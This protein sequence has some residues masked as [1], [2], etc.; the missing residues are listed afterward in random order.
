M[1]T[2]LSSIAGCLH[3]S[4]KFECRRTDD[5]RGSGEH[6]FGHAVQSMKKD[7]S[8]YHSIMVLRSHAEAVK[9]SD[10]L[11][12]CLFSLP[13]L[14]VANS[15]HTHGVRLSFV[16]VA[17]LCTLF[18]LFFLWHHRSRSGLFALLLTSSFFFHPLGQGCVLVSSGVFINKA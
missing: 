8:I 14:R 6:I 4:R 5:R 2:D 10:Q 17:L 18:F 3:R 15:T 1:A 12:P 9:F 16:Y 7:G 11:F 13:S